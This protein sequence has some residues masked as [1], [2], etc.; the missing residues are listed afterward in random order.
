MVG[1]IRIDVS[2]SRHWKYKRLKRRVGVLP[3]GYLVNFWVAVAEQKS[4]GVLTG[5]AA[6]DIEDAADWDGDPGAFFCGL[7]EAGFIDEVDGVLVVHD[8]AENQPWAS[9]AVPRADKSRLANMTKTFPG[10]CQVFK[11]AGRSGISSDEYIEIKKSSD[12][13]TTAKQ[14]VGFSFTERERDVNGT[15]SPSPS[16]SPK[17]KSKS[18][19][20]AAKEPSVEVDTE[21]DETDETLQQQQLRKVIFAK[22]KNLLRLT[23]VTAET[24]EAVAEHCVAF[25]RGRS[26]GADPY[27]VALAWFKRERAGPA[28]GGNGRGG[29]MS[30]MAKGLA[31]FDEIERR[32]SDEVGGG[33]GDDGTAAALLAAAGSH[34]GSG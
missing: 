32:S 24:F 30:Q 8:W 25:Y 16:P 12:K 1:D 34:S 21:G 4:D 15:F 27:A 7:S 9:E 20:V 6:E 11:E 22:R 29:G 28:L 26:L 5:W 18:K 33:G 3:M 17:P 19:A 13:L 31:V 14:I 10:V 2:L 23:A